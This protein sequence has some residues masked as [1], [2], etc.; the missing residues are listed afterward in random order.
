MARNPPLVGHFPVQTALQK[1]PT[2][3][4]ERG[5]RVTISAQAPAFTLKMNARS[6]AAQ[7]R[8]RVGISHA[9]EEVAGEY[10]QQEASTWPRQKLLDLNAF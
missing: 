7:V 9:L 10:V 6:G 1:Q 8:G 5:I 2:F 3:P 4:Q